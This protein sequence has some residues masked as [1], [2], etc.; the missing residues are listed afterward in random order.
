MADVN[1][2]DEMCKEALAT[3]RLEELAFIKLNSVIAS[4]VKMFKGDKISIDEASVFINAAIDF[5]REAVT[6][7]VVEAI[8]GARDVAL[9]NGV[10]DEEERLVKISNDYINKKRSEVI[11]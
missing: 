3:G 5:Y 11:K 1:V 9:Y 8:Y 10:C 4:V 7:D 2:V 6:C